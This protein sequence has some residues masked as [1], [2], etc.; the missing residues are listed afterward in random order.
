[1]QYDHR[2]EDDDNVVPQCQCVCKREWIKFYPNE[3]RED[4]IS[5]K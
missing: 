2:E 5:S 4:W 1:M 3:V